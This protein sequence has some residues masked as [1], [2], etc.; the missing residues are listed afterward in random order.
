MS[1]DGWCDVCQTTTDGECRHYE[2]GT[3]LD[4]AAE[5]TRLHGLVASAR[6]WIDPEEH[7]AWEEQASAEATSC[8]REIDRLRGALAKANEQVGDLID[9]AAA[10]DPKDRVWVLV[11]LVELA[12]KDRRIVK[13]EAKARE[14]KAEITR[15]RGLVVSA[16]NWINPKEHPAWEEQASAEATSC[17]RE[18]ERLREELKIC[19]E[20]RDDW[21]SQ[22]DEML[23]RIEDPESGAKLLGRSNY[24]LCEKL[25]AAKDRIEELE[26]D[27]DWW[28]SV[29]CDYKRDLGEAIR[30]GP[31]GLAWVMVTHDQIDAAWE[32]R[33][34]DVVEGI[35]FIPASEIGI[36]ACDRCHGWGVI[37][38][39]EESPRA[40]DK[41]SNC[42]GH[43]WVIGGEDE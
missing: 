8:S 43:G 3:T 21:H 38:I 18:I 36:R 10:G 33:H 24:E 28:A 35:M 29:A 5:I 22:C 6:N 40:T 2:D 37:P 12:E 31:H 14:R 11:T 9:D 23:E 4:A 27:R 26:K 1:D 32:E 19:Q 39:N 17:S 25:N 7:L 41:C 16:Q 42:D 20:I 13:L 30:R 15:L 34:D